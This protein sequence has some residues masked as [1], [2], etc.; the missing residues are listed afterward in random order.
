MIFN[1]PKKRNSRP[2]QQFIILTELWNEA[3][4]H[5]TPLKKRLDLPNG[6]LSS[7]D[8]CGDESSIRIKAN[9][10]IENAQSIENV[11][12]KYCYACNN[13]FISKTEYQEHLAKW[14]ITRQPQSIVSQKNPIITGVDARLWASKPVVLNIEPTT[15]CN[16]NCWYC[17]GRSMVQ[18]DI[19][20]NG[21]VSAIDNFPTLQIVAIVGEGEPLLHKQFFDMVRVCK[22]RGLRVVTVSNGSP[23]SESVVKKLCESGVDYIA[24]SIDSIN[25]KTFA[26]SRIDGD[27][28][29]VWS[30]IKRLADY[31]NANGYR[32]P[33]IG[34][35]GTL[36][37][38]TQ[39]ELPAITMEAKKHGVDMFE[40][41]QS[42]NPKKTYVNIYPEDKI[43]LL[44]NAPSISKRMS[45]EFEKSALPSVTEFAIQEG[46][47]IRND[48]GPNGIR[49][50]CNEEWIYSLLS[51]D[52][53]P[54]CQIK[55]PIDDNWN[56]FKSPISEILN[57]QHYQN[58]RFNLWNGIF[59]TEC[60]GCTKTRSS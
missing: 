48:G 57:N 59:L 20:F 41:F 2:E 26:D 25:P 9:I 36:F 55:T 17:I 4:A 5:L 24:V 12:I 46:M 56:L 27:L 45:E 32:Y 50:N 10:R 40:A 58:V 51:G 19:D 15:R 43:H 7:C 54:C 22:E 18:A 30:N 47:A 44:K 21:F 6:S 14:N 39:D 31:K 38:H 52:V 1:W 23:F 13:Y 53:T 28:E 34:L 37:D 29:K 3:H 35:K 42:L 33:M 60:E 11:S 16:F 49:P 8:C